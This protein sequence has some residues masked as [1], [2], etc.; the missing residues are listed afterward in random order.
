V[1]SGNIKYENKHSGE[2]LINPNEVDLK[3]TGDLQK[4]CK[5]L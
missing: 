2:Y 4:L 1:V 3:I 5:E